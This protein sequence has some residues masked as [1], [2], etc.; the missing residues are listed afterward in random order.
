MHKA[1]LAHGS[2][3]RRDGLRRV[4]PPHSPVHRFVSMTSVSMARGPLR[5]RKYPLLGIP[6]K[7]CE[8]VFV[9]TTR[10]WCRVKSGT[11]AL[12]G[13]PG[14]VTDCP[15]DDARRFESGLREHLDQCLQQGIAGLCKGQ[16]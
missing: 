4:V 16:S 13:R 2:E 3:A 7:P 1:P 12:R 15:F 9:V 5:V 14:E 11:A 10:D 6:L 8:A